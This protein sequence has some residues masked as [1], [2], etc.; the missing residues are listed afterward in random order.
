[1]GEYCGCYRKEFSSLCASRVQENTT[2]QGT[3]RSA[4]ML[5]GVFAAEWIPEL[6]LSG[7]QYQQV[8]PVRIPPLRVFRHVC[9]I[10]AVIVKLSDARE[11][12]SPARRARFT[13]KYIRLVKR[14]CYCQRSQILA[15]R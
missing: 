13:E 5:P 14:N 6:A 2:V 15:K 12:H 10:G 4:A 3:E 7:D 8:C 1:M 11:P 9:D